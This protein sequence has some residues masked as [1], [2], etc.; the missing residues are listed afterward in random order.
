M[1]RRIRTLRLQAAAALAGLLTATALAAAPATAATPAPAPDYC[2]NRCHDILPPGENGNATLADI[3]ANRLLGTRPAHTDDQL[4]PYAA[5]ANSY[6]GLTDA[7]LR[8]FFND[9]SFGVPAG[10]VASTLQPRPDVTI[11]RDK[12]TGVPH[13]TGTT[14]YGTE[15]GAGYAAAQDRLWL[16]DL[17]RHV[18]RGQLSSFAGGAADNRALEQS[19]WQAAPYTEAELQQQIDTLAASGPRAAQAMADAGAY[20]DGINAY[21]DTAYSSRTFPGEYDLTGHIDPLTN[22]G[23]IDH[24][25]LTDLVALASVVGALFGAGGGG[26]VQSAQVKLAAEARYGKAE[27]DRVWASFREADDP[28]AV[29][30]LHDGQRFPYA[31][32]P[33]DPQGTAMP[34]PG[35]VVPEKLVYDATGTGATTAATAAKGVLPGNLLTARHGMSNALVVSGRYAADGHPVAVFGPQTGYFAPQLLMLEELQG[36]GISARG[37]AFAGLS[38][39][40]QLGRGQDYAWS[41]TSAGQDIT[42]SYAVPLCTTDGSPATLAS[43][44]Y[45]WHGRCT[46]ME[47]LERKDSWKPTTADSTGAGSYTLVMK[48]TRYGLVTSRGTVGG[49]P[50]AFTALRSTYR[51]EADSIVGFQMLN[52][53]AAV[54]SAAT[55]QEAAQHINYTF[56]WFYADAVDTAYYNSGD[57]PVR[58]DGVDPGLPVLAEPQYEWRGYDP[59]ANTAEYTPPAQHPQSVNQD[60]YISWNNKQAD[61]FTT[62]GFGNGSVHRADLLDDR[63]RALL[64]SG[65]KV[66]RSALVRAMESAALADLRGEDVLPDLLRVIRSG[67]VTDPALAGAV[68]KLETWRADGTLRRETSAGSHRYADADAVRIMDAWWPLLVQAEFRAGLGDPLFTALTGA[69][70]L[71]ESPSGGQTGPVSGSV[72]ANESIPHKGSAFQYGWWSYVDKDLRTV[73]GDPVAGG[74]G[75]PYCGGGDLARCRSV[76]LE[77]LRQAAAQPAAQVYPADDVCSAGDQWCADTIV[78]RPLGG[79]TDGK[80]SWQNRPTYQQVVQFTSHR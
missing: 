49:T 31:Q 34:D 40:V 59:D 16:M 6:P 48:R 19:F 23:S 10:Q 41:A 14:R 61:A 30:T 52:D 42:D 44:S 2:G 80:V 18:G 9:A 54:H 39:Y 58:A 12:A 25:R 79:V 7:G 43:D 78:Q 60:Y 75:G 28:E 29:T 8:S 67:A 1:Q 36:P 37:A 53:P 76:L 45:L 24:F 72:S 47:R 66:T 74:L 56:N 50:V 57:N 38:F 46:P 77:S 69:L 62:A 70:Q 32:P 13:V 11:V 17:F 26:E 51:H 21:I 63:V 73:L 3:L 64:G 71:N 27:G 55:F 4:G 20:L 65:A 33:A 15:Y 5:L 35:S 68:Q 22:A